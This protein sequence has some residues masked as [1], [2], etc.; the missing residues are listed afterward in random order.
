MHEAVE[1][2]LRNI[3]ELPPLPLSARQILRALNGH[4][5]V[6]TELVSAVELDPV[7][8]A[9]LIA[10]ANSAYFQTT[11]PCT[12][13]R[14]AIVR[15]GLQETKQLLLPIVL[16]SFFD[17]RKCPNFRVDEYWKQ[18]LL[19]AMGARKV[20]ECAANKIDETLSHSAYTAGLFHNIGLLALVHLFPRE[21]NRVF[22]QNHDFNSNYD[23]VTAMIGI[24]PSEASYILLSSWGVP[25]V[26][27][28]VVRNIYSDY[29]V[30]GKCSDL[31]VL[32]K[33]MVFWY[34]QDFCPIQ[35]PDELQRIGIQTQDL[36]KA[37]E[38]IQRDLPSLVKIA[39]MLYFY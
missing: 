1:Y 29:P 36:M 13:V 7:V 24:D 18:I 37:Q 32:I 38:L 14:D 27:F 25:E 21:M 31:T 20:T 6:I 12:H 8:T 19:V 26:L 34:T 10:I 4:E 17:L 16:A 39:N 15:L 3:K 23:S 5:V 33:F 2:S 11:H 9:R 28:N 30:S 22:R 35:A